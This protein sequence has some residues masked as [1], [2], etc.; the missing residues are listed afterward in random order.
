MLPRITDAHYFTGHIIRLRFNEGTEGEFDLFNELYGEVFEPLKEVC[1]FRKFQLN[2]E[3]RTI[4]WPNGADFAPEFLR[5][6]VK[7]AA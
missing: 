2:P 3:L 6:L 7:V 4:V 5:S 1:Y